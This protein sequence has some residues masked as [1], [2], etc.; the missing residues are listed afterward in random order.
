MKK[1]LAV[2]LLALLFN[3]CEKS[4]EEPSNA[5][6]GIVEDLNKSK[7]GDDNKT[8]PG[9]DNKTIPGEN[10]ETGGD[11]NASFEYASLS[12][13]VEYV[14]RYKVKRTTPSYFELGDS[15][16]TRYNEEAGVPSMCYT[17]HEGNYNP[18]YVCHQDYIKKE[19]RANRAQDGFLQ[20][21]YAFSDF[22]FTNHWHNLFQD[23]SAEADAIT[24]EEILTYINTENY[25]ALA[26][27]LVEHNFTG[28]IP[29]LENMHL[30]AA[31]FDDEGF[32]KDGSGWVAFNY[33]PLPS[34]FWPV[35][36]STDDVLI[37]LAKPFR[38]TAEGNYSRTVYRFNLAIVE[39]TLKNL[40]TISVNSLDERLIGIDMNGDSKLG[41]V[42]SINRPTHYVGA[43][44]SVPIE[45]FLYPLYTEFLHSV[46]YIG[47]D[48]NGS[49]YNAPHM[50]ELR[51]MIKVRSY[52]DKSLPMTKVL[53]A[54]IYD[55]E[56]QEKIEGN[57]IPNFPSLGEKGLDNKMGWWLQAFIEDKDGA[58]RP[59]EYEET[60]FCMGCHTNLGST[61][62]QTFAFGRK[63]DG[64][65]GWGY[66]NLHG[67]KDAP[68]MGESEG[69]IATY[70]KRVGGGNEFRAQND[71][72]DNFFTA[73]ELDETKL[74]SAKD[75]YE[76]IT[77]SRANA[78]RMSKSYRVIVQHQSFKDGRDG[79]YQAEPN[80][81][82]SV[83]DMTPTLPKELQHKWDIRLD[84]N[85]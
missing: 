15:Q 61:L 6:K 7:P 52:E 76:M 35:N 17:K 4:S 1:V 54:K 45:T 51:Y 75:V 66:I 62:D 2:A 8:T 44:S 28:Y 78:L 74:N 26:P 50:K 38:Q 73:G 67:M 63:I 19:G 82:Q 49:I 5:P 83:N 84:W 56:Y 72:V 27:T 16:V 60:F 18:C 9:D 48:E 32:A 77:P 53:L 29:D 70:L 57:N 23:R 10:N 40:T 20:N 13:G 14:D 47:V 80:V 34:T 31:A 71:V 42:T 46:R 24:D 55:D 22:A 11:V 43:A 39:A 37:R 64:A 30:G 79:N 68:N 41:M 3:A 85:K 33:K 65:S 25:S 58:L 69:E 59:Q 81:Y 12:K 36:G 21:E